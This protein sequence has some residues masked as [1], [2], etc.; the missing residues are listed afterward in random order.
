[1]ALH[2]HFKNVLKLIDLTERNSGA[3]CPLRD[4]AE[5]D[6]L[7]ALNAHGAVSV[8]EAVLINELLEA[9]TLQK[10]SVEV[11][12]KALALV[13]TGQRLKG[14][15]QVPQSI[16]NVKDYF[17]SRDWMVF[18]RAEVNTILDVMIGRLGRLGVLYPTEKSL[19]KLLGSQRSSPR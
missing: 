5:A 15:K 19:K 13:T 3:T 11:V 2:L 1:M 16:D 14:A 18:R 12:S 17:T 9:S 10:S 7:R 4:R 8:D 6:L